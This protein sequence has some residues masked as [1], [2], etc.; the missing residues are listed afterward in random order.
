MNG[1]PTGDGKEAAP[2]SDH[3][4]GYLPEEKLQHLR[5]QKM[6]AQFSK[7]DAV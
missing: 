2:T 1:E 4:N 3:F 5:S 6:Y 7:L